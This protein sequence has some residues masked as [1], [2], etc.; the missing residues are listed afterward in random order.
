M[1]DNNDLRAKMFRLDR[2]QMI[3][4]MAALGALAGVPLRQA[5]GQES[6]RKQIPKYPRYASVAFGMIQAF[7]LYQVFS[8]PRPLSR[9][10][11]PAR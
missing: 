8:R 9:A 1:T 11:A 3:S 5:M 4:G 6:G 7:G 10:P 2:R